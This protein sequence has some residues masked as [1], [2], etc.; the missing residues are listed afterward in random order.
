MGEEMEDRKVAEL[1]L[2]GRCPEAKSSRR[3]RGRLRSTCQ[4]AA[5]ILEGICEVELC[6]RGH[7]VR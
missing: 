1:V 2:E 3:R 4:A 7:R 6:L 5:E